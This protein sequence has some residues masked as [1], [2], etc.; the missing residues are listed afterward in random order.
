MPETVKVVGLREAN[1]ALRRLPVVAQDG[2]QKVMDV[3][4]FQVS[5]T[6]SSHAPHSADG[7]HGRAAGFLAR[8]IAWKSRPRSLSAVVTVAAEAFYWKFVEFGTRRMAA[9]PFFRPAADG[10]RDDHH[11]RMIDALSKAASKI[12]REANG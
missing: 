3:T 7:S 9:Q 6:A 10:V 12:A 1:R 8:A 5:R 2:S 4:A 11:R